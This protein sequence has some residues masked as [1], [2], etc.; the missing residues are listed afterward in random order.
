MAFAA[1]SWDPRLGP[2]TGKQLG[3]LPFFN[4]DLYKSL[5]SGRAVD[6]GESAEWA[7][8]ADGRQ[9]MSLASQGWCDASVAAGTDQAAARAAADRTTAAYTVIAVSGVSPPEDAS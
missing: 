8:S 4:L 9:F 6:P 5:S 2:V 3:P 1:S 7:S